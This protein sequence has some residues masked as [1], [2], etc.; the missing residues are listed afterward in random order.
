MNSEDIAKIVGVSRSTVSRV[1]NNYP[2]IPPATREKV[3]KA[4]KEYNYYPNAS[5]RRLAGM[6]NSTLGIFVIDIKDNEKPHHVI[7]NDE[8]LLYGNA[9][10]APFINAF[11]DQANKTQ[12]YVLVSTIYCSDELW[13]I[14]SAFCEKRIDAGVIIGCS[15]GDYNQII[16]TLEKGSIIA[17][18]DIDVDDSNKDMGLYI[19]INNNQG[20]YD[21]AKYLI[22]LGHTNI[23]IITGDLDKLSGKTRFVSFK[24][25]LSDCCV[26]LHDNLIA[27]GDFTE[28]S[29]YHG[30]K[31]I[32]TAENRPTAV[33]VCNDTMAVGAYKA[34]IESGFRIPDDISVIGFDNTQISA[35]MSPPLTTVNVYLAEVAKNSVDLLIESIEKGRCE[36][37][38]RTV[39]VK[40]IE[41]ESCI[42][43]PVRDNEL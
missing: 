9:Y 31:K 24:Q 11:I 1:I 22:D 19:N 41:R 35:Y 13:K 43:F 2:D 5:A 28:H 20:A 36:A 12:Y 23:G 7:Q 3:L 15:K 34:I 32:L 33:F 29:G 40:I 26:Q 30:M 21:A 39:D 37:I 6:K 27:Y 10:F 16:K 25:A 42:P 17:A 4:I 18:V 38:Q 8:D 14:Q